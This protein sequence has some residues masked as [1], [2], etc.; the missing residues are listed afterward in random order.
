MKLLNEPN[1]QR[2]SFTMSDEFRTLP[3]PYAPVGSGPNQSAQQEPNAEVSAWMAKTR[4]YFAAFGGL[5]AGPGIPKSFIA[6]V[7]PDEDDSDEE[8]DADDH[9]DDDYE[10]ED[11]DEGLTG[12]IQHLTLKR[13]PSTGSRGKR[14][15]ISRDRSSA[16]GSPKSFSG[17]KLATLPPEVFPMGLCLENLE[18]EARKC[19][20]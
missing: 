18:E 15:S 13:T 9:L 10:Y 4:E 1:G 5:I 14:R 11:D 12:D 19:R 7:D 3:T 6:K 2:H 8:Q 17:D 20:W 16:A